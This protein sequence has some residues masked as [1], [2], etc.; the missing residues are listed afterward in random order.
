M[1]M[2]I[3]ICT[4]CSYVQYVCECV[5]VC[6]YVYAHMRA[7]VYV[8]VYLFVMLSPTERVVHGGGYPQCN[9]LSVIMGGLMTHCHLFDAQHHTAFVFLLCWEVKGWRNKGEQNRT[10][11]SRAEERYKMFYISLL[12]M[13]S[14][15]QWDEGIWE[16]KR[17]EGCRESWGGEGRTIKNVC[18]RCSLSLRFVIWH[19]PSHSALLVERD[20]WVLPLERWGERTHTHPH[21]DTQTHKCTG[22]IFAMLNKS[23]KLRRF[24]KIWNCFCIA[25]WKQIF[26]EF[27]Q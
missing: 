3:Y 14:E 26:L 16:M 21:T 6:T 9:A 7:C 4:V 20:C 23:F 5:R 1:C 22:S 8:C 13:H 27:C 10:K 24:K 19:H 25:V 18:F 15:L 12:A 2:H 17:R 11:E